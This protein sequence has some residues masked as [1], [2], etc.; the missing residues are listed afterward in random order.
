MIPNHVCAAV[1]AL[2][3]LD[4]FLNRDTAEKWLNVWPGR[5]TLSVEEKVQVLAHFD[6]QLDHATTGTS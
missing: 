5:W 3:R 1:E 6:D 4:P 2:R